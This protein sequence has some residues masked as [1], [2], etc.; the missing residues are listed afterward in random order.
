MRHWPGPSGATLG[1]TTRVARPIDACPHHALITTVLACRRCMARFWAQM[2]A[3][4][5]GLAPA[6]RP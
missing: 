4:D 2:R 5:A 3:L 1:T 6:S